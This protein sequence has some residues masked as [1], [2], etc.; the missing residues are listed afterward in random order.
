[1][2]Y[3]KIVLLLICIGM[4]VF[5]LGGCFT[6]NDYPSFRELTCRCIDQDEDMLLEL[7]GMYEDNIITGIYRTDDKKFYVTVSD[8]QGVDTASKKYTRACE[9]LNHLISE[10]KVSDI[11][12]YSDIR[13]MEIWFE[14]DFWDCDWGITY[15]PPGVEPPD[16]IGDREHSEEIKDGF[17]TYLWYKSF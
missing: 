17:Y 4:L 3:R 16:D 15:Y 6:S 14:E 9:I 1:M 13:K 12:Y 2:R 5:L 11:N 7:Y 8:K 10:Y